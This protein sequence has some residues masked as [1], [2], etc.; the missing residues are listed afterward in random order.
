M[1][2]IKLNPDDSGYFP[3]SVFAHRYAYVLAHGKIP[4]GYWVRHRCGNPGCVNP[5]HL[6]ATKEK[7]RGKRY[8]D[9]V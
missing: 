4:T 7:G 1:S 9:P 3:A 5:R 6:Y 2:L 8:N